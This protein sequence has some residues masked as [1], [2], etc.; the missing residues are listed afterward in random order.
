ME[1]RALVSKQGMGSE[2]EVGSFYFAAN[3]EPLRFGLDG[4]QLSCPGSSVV[5]DKGK[6]Q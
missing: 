5:A 3:S 1:E 4:S 6:D 2:S